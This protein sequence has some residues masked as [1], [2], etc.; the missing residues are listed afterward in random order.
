MIGCVIDVMACAETFC[1]LFTWGGG[2]TFC[3][4]LRSP[5]CDLLRSPPPSKLGVRA[6][7]PETTFGPPSLKG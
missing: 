4:L 3:D 6:L 5:F 1:D 7:Y 2:L